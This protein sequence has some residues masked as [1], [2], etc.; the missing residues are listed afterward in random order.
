MNVSDPNEQISSF[1]DGELQGPARGRIVHALYGSPEL[2]RRW[3]RY[4]LIGDAARKI[5]PVSG[6]DS[7]AGN[8]GA[9]LSGESMVSFKRRPWLVPLPG[10]ALAASIAAVAILGIRGLDD[11]GAQSPPVAGTQSPP[12]AGAQSPPVAGASRHEAAAESPLSTDPG[13]TVSRIASGAVQSAGSEAVRRPWSDAAPDAEARLNVYLVN[14]NEY[15]GNGV[16]GV[17]P[18]VRIVG[19]QSMGEYR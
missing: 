3:A 8:V 1:V 9:A 15:A 12:V 19:Y 5:G 10:L 17:L 7:I 16:R 4:H 13:S 18:Y 14:H 11:G 6:A 2:R